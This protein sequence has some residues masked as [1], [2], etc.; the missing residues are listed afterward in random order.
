MAREAL[1]NLLRTRVDLD[2]ANVVDLF[3][4]TGF[5]SFE[6]CSRGAKHVTA[7]EKHRGCVKFI[8]QTAATLGISNLS[9]IQGD[10]FRFLKMGSS[11]ADLVFAD[12]P[13]DLPNLSDLADTILE[14]NVLNPEGLLIIEH[15]KS[16][17]F[18]THPCF[19]EERRYGSVHFSF[20]IAPARPIAPRQ[21]L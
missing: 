9:V 10:V 4:G 14:E 1:F 11:H 12:P 2:E 16:T 3:S 20:F 19:Q 8:T 7:V 15:G 18:H 21:E 6:F 13:Y 5:I 17:H